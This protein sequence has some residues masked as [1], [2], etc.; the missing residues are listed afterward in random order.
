MVVLPDCCP[1]VPLLPLLPTVFPVAVVPTVF[2]EALVR[3]ERLLP[4]PGGGRCPDGGRMLPAEAMASVGGRWTRGG[5]GCSVWTT[6][7][8]VGQKGT[9][10]VVLLSSLVETFR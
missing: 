10:N 2:K 1:V 8:W 6:T 5:C 7:V 3:P 9:R 4:R